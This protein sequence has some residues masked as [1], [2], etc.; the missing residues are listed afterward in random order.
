VLIAVRSGRHEGFDRA[1]FEF[2]DG[3]PGYRIE[4]VKPPIIADPSGLP[5]QIAG[6][7]FLQVRMEPAAGHDPNT[8]ASTAPIE[9]STGLPSLVEMKRAGDFEAVLTWVLGLRAEV[10]FR[11]FELMEPF[12]LVI[13]VKHP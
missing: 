7:A 13:D 5:V 12:R 11:V 10:D 9:V 2:R 4:Y 1:V 3:L 8:G 6:N